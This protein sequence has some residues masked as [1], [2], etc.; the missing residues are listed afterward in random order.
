MRI[1]SN[2]YR[3]QSF[4]LHTNASNTVVVVGNSGATP[5]A[6]DDEVVAGATVRRI[7]AACGSSGVVTIARGSNTIFSTTVSC[8]HD[9]AGHGASLNMDPAANVVITIAGTATCTME[10]GKQTTANN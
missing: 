7:W 3:G 8:F 2:K 1:V 9:Y 5:L 4:V 10:L 6:K